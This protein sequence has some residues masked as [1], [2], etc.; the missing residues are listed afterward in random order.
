MKQWFDSIFDS[1]TIFTDFG[2]PFFGSPWSLASSFTCPWPLA[3]TFRNLTVRVAIAPGVGNSR[4]YTLVKNGSNTSLAVTISGTDTE[5]ELQGVDVSVAAGDSITLKT[6]PVDG[7]TGTP[8]ARVRIEFESDSDTVS[9]YSL[10]RNATEAGIRYNG[11]FRGMG[12]WSA[13]PVG[14]NTND[15]VG[16]DGT[17]TDLQVTLKTAPGSGN[18]WVFT[19]Y[20]NDVKQ[21]GSGGTVDTAITIADTDKTGSISFSLPLVVGDRVCIESEP[22]SSPTAA[23]LISWNVL[24]DADEPH[25]SNICGRQTGSMN[26][27]ATAYTHVMDRLNGFSVA[28]TESN[29][30]TLPTVTP[31]KLV[32]LIVALSGAPGS[33][34]SYV[35]DGR[36]DGTSPGGTPTVTI[37]GTDTEGSEA[38]LL[39]VEAGGVCSLRIVPDS[40]PTAR[41][42]VWAFGLLMG[43]PESTPFVQAWVY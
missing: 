41:Q 7:P 39:E 20:K 14:F 21:D 1:H 9:A 12:N 17:L 18:S 38:G 35:F 11:V 23:D 27:A 19:L 25:M 42:A 30:E 26:N 13:G 40:T 43:E 37:A 24:F 3:G 15:I 6:T 28:T 36:V 5:G 32:H 31:F 33:G 2:N 8:Q 34:N 16:I 22:V 10:T 29:V 4:I